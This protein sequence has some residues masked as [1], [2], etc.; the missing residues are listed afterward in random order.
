MTT[1]DIVRILI[2]E[3][4]FYRRE[5]VN[6]NLNLRQKENGRFVNV[7]FRPITENDQPRR[8]KRVNDHVEALL[9]EYWA[10]AYGKSEV[11]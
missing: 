1:Q 6:K 10:G 7:E 4:K 9:Q 3:G 8:V 11:H 5:S 2:R